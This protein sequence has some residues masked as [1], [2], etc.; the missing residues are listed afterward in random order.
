[1]PEFTASEKSFHNRRNE[2]IVLIFHF[3]GQV[4]KKVEILNHHI[5]VT[6][7]ICLQVFKVYF[8]LWFCFQ[9]LTNIHRE[10]FV[11]W[12]KMKQKA[13]QW[14][15]GEEEEGQKKQ[16]HSADCY[17]SPQSVSSSHIDP[18]NFKTNIAGEDR[19]DKLENV[20]RVQ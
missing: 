6:F 1:M 4:P 14:A 5:Q 8:E 15:W 18:N 20:C 9:I 7:Q 13:L 3:K 17:Q 2:P 10:S 12:E 19:A 16:I 11:G